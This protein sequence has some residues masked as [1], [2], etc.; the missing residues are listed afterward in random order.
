MERFVSLCIQRL[1]THLC[2]TNIHS[3]IRHKCLSG[4]IKSLNGYPARYISISSKQRYSVFEPDGIGDPPEIDEYSELKISLQGFDFVVLESF[5]RYVHR[6]LRELEFKNNNFAVPP[7][8]TKVQTYVPNSDKLDQ[9]FN[10]STY[11][12]SFILEDVPCTKLPLAIEIMQQN[13][14]AGVELSIKWPDVMEEEFRYI[15][16]KEILDL[17]EQLAEIDQIRED[18]KKK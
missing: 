16:D 7:K 14:P 2:R 17:Q 3:Q 6:L 9:E 5:S 13:L 4:K 11:E 12:R 18:R 8:C 10:L 1:G 15:P